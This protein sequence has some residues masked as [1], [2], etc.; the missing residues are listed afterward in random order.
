MYLEAQSSS[1]KL[2]SGRIPEQN[3]PAAKIRYRYK[4]DE[5]PVWKTRALR[6]TK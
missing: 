2:Q 6:E 4:K 3:N 5:V 1:N